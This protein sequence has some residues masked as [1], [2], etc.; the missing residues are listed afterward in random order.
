MSPHKISRSLV[1]S[2]LRT[3][4]FP[5]KNN[6]KTLKNRDIFGI[7]I[8]FLYLCNPILI[9]QVSSVKTYRIVL[10]GGW[11]RFLMNLLK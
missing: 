10:L 11:F 9:I 4:V 7:S 8:Y 2:A 3:E 5:A 6:F 1:F